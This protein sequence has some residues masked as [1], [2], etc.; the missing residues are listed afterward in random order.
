[1][2]CSLNTFIESLIKDSATLLAKNMF[3]FLYRK[4]GS[5][6]LEQVSKVDILQPYGIV[7]F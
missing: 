3:V 5:L 1:M 7:E 2:A 4:C 6:K